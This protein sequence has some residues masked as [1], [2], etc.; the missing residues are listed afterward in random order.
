MKRLL[1]YLAILAAL[2]PA[3]IWASDITAAK[4]HG[5]VRVTNNGTATANV[6][7]PLALDTASF[8]TN[9]YS[10]A[11]ASDV[12]FLISGTDTAFMPGYG[13]N[14]WMFFTGSLGASQ[15]TDYDLY[16]R[17]VTGG[18]VAYFPGT[19]GMT[20]TDNDSLELGDYFNVFVSGYID[21]TAGAG[22][23]II[24][25]DDTFQL[26]VS[27]SVSG[28][29]TA[30]FTNPTPAFQWVSPTGWEDD[31][32]WSSEAN[33]Y[34]N[35]T[36][37]YATSTGVYPGQ[38]T[39]V[40]T[41]TISDTNSDRIRYY[42]PAMSSYYWDSMM[43]RVYYSSAWHTIYL[44]GIEQLQWVTKTIG[45]TQTVSKVGFTFYRTWND[46][47]AFSA[48][49]SEV[50]VGE[51]PATPDD[52]RITATGVVSG[53]HT[54][55]V[56][57]YPSPLSYFALHIDEELV[58]NAD[59][60]GGVSDNSSN[61]NLFQ[62]SVMP[63]IYSANISVGGTLVGSWAWQ[64][65]TVFYDASGYGNTGTPTFRTTSSDADVTASLVYFTPVTETAVTSFD[66]TTAGSII[67]TAPDVIPQLFTE[68]DYSKVPGAAAVNEVLA[69]AGIPYAL[70]WVWFIY[71]MI[72]VLGFLAYGLT[73]MSSRG[74]LNDHEGALLVEAIV[75]E[76]LLSLVGIIGLL[77]WW[78][79]LLFPIPALAIIISKKH[80]SWG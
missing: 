54:I 21:T 30:S 43:V 3:S 7:V 9:G 73:S 32:G 53:E 63:Y 35:N 36:G 77:P 26:Y 75:I 61:W 68:G 10:N 49:V 5:T 13:G 67:T 27:D 65:D 80:Y 6:S 52:I 31:A 18:T 56:V 16:S 46:N 70:F 39:T 78:P 29:I 40:L 12:A 19:A 28:N 76:M 44:G 64:Y 14:P 58:D 62:N 22:K 15:S 23:N 50:M 20:V 8:I 2:I 37:T 60:A 17:G 47:D 24:F 1:I 33:T 42:L 74:T 34:D 55:R 25:K 38:S 4:W 69:A 57:G 71:P 79:A 72:G 11:T 66:L 59:L 48:Y 41:L 51:Q 45:S